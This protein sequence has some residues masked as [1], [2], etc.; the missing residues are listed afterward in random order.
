VHIVVR[1]D[2]GILSVRDLKGKRVSLDREGSGT[3]V[4]AL[5]VLEAYGLAPKDLQ[6][7][8]L[9]PGPAADQVRDGSLDAFFL[10]AGVPAAAISDLAQAAPIAFVPIT[11]PEAERLKQTYPFFS[12]NM[13]P[14]NSYA[15]IYATPTVSVGAQ[16][17]VAAEVPEETVY[18]VT[19]ALWHASTHA[20]LAPGHPP[21]KSFHC[22]A[23]P[24]RH[25]SP[26]PPWPR[27][28]LPRGRDPAKMTCQDA[29]SPASRAITRAPHPLPFRERDE[30]FTSPA[31]AGE[32][33]RGRQGGP[34]EGATGRGT[35]ALCRNLVLG[36][37][38]AGF[39]QLAQDD[40]ALEGSQ[41]VDK[42]H[43]VEMV[44]LVLQAGGQQSRSLDLP[45]LVVIVEIADLDGGGTRHF[46][47][48]LR[49]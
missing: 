48:M 19:K 26:P 22:A 21:R 28:P 16:W 12:T 18:G 15:G 32:E 17:L 34:G 27:P 38:F 39:G 11:G 41:V 2:S 42:Q 49:H 31:C 7:E 10:V 5:L 8:H 13:I 20:L 36:G 43:A 37:G 46:R 44:D 45:D 30:A 3:L 33:G 35:D 14:A 40:A 9:E 29:P 24:R 25:R 1:R 23:S 4:D 47:V 6:I